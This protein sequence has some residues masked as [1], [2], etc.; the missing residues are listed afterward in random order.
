MKISFVLGHELPFPPAGGGGVNSLLHA[1]TRALARAGHDVVAYSPTYDR[2][3]DEEF[4]D[5]V[6]HIRV[7]GAERHPGNFHNQLRGVPYAFRVRARLEKCDILSCH[8]LTSFVFKPSRKVPV[9]THTIH[10]DPKLYLLLTRLL[11]RIYTGSEAVTEAA[12][13][14]IPQLLPKL[15]TVHNCIDFSG[16]PEQQA[17]RTDPFTFIYVG[18]F[19]RDKGIETFVRGFMEAADSCPNIRL[20]TVGPLKGEQGAEVDFVEEVRAL[21]SASRFSDRIEILPAIYDRALLDSQIRKAQVVVLP[22]LG[23]E[24]LNMSILECLRL[25]R[26]VIISDLAANIPLVADGVSGLLAKVGDVTDWARAIRQMAALDSISY[27]KM[28]SNAYKYGFEHFA[29]DAI[30]AVYV[31]DF[32]DLL[33]RKMV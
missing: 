33:Q 24:T 30:A 5:G 18:R 22:S 17:N 11:D 10:R 21:V 29:S 32:L 25:T 14:A 13:Q 20:Q 31:N 6:R 28:A 19:T 12:G 7:R 3:P 4:L 2:Y 15:K 8:L 23:G 1:L 16:Y 26:P 9:V 27:S